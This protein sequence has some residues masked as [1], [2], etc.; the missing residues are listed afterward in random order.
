MTFCVSRNCQVHEISSHWLEV[1]TNQPEIVVS[2]VKFFPYKSAI[3]ECARLLGWKAEDP[4]CT[5]PPTDKSTTWVLVLP[6]TDLLYNKLPTSYSTC[7]C[8][9]VWVELYFEATN[10]HTLTLI[11][12][13]IILYYHRRSMRRTS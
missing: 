8:S 7:S 5:T 6:P 4:N 2:H 9:G 3:R 10:S 11:R 12:N 1:N 13:S